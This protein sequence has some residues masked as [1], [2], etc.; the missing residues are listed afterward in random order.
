MSMEHGAGWL[1]ILVAVADAVRSVCLLT[2]ARLRGVR[3]SAVPASV[4]SELLLSPVLLSVGSHLLG[5]GGPRWRGWGALALCAAS[6]ALEVVHG[7]VSRKK[8]GLAWWRFG[9]SVPS[10]ADGSAE[11]GSQPGSA[12]DTTR[13]KL[14]TSWESWSLTSARAAC[15]TR[16]G[17]ATSSS[18]RPGCGPATS[19]GKSTTFS[20]RSSRGRRGEPVTAL[21]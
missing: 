1:I 14:T 6:L 20:T 5:H 7:V 9:T 3:L 21:A 19:S 4:W 17:C 18:P 10:S 2:A 11:R 13:K 16:R 12:E 8:A 15:W